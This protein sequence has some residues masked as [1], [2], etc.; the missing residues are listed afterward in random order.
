MP[1]TTLKKEKKH[2]TLNLKKERKR[3]SEK[4]RLGYKEKTWE[5]NGKK[6][7][8]EIHI[9]AKFVSM[10]RWN[11]GRV[12]KLACTQFHPIASIIAN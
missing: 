8:S 2:I 3:P 6:T 11:D 7:Q 4:S 1:K 5:T 9:D 12:D 10:W